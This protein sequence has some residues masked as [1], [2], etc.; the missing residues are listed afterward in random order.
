MNNILEKIKD[1]KIKIIIIGVIVI[2]LG[3]ILLCLNLGED[4]NTEELTFIEE[5]T[6]TTKKLE[7][8]YVDIK[9]SVNNPGVYEFKENDRVIDAIKLA[10][11]LTNN[12]N[13]S[14]I[15]LS[16]KLTSEMVIYV[17]NNNE[18]NNN[19]PKLTCDTVCNTQVIEVNNCIEVTTKKVDSENNTKNDKTNGIVNINTASIDELMTLSGIGE[20]KAKNI[21]EYRSTNGKFNTIE[22]IKNISGIGDALFNK[23]KDNITV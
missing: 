16:Q 17:Y 5:T 4:D 8:N 1:N 22:D 18:I 10:G 6:T 3:V 9:G 20:S 14:N 11:G 19:A 2:L 21:I 15:N 23:I 7:K 13:T 12:A